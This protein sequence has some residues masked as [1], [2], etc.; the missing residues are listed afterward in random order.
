MSSLPPKGR[1][2][3]RKEKESTGGRG[4]IWRRGGEEV[5]PPLKLADTSL[6]PASAGSNSSNAL[7]HYLS[8]T[9]SRICLTSHPPGARGFRLHNDTRIKI[10]N[11]TTPLSPARPKTTSVCNGCR[12]GRPFVSHHFF[13]VIFWTPV[14]PHLLQIWDRFRV[15]I[16]TFF[17]LFFASIFQTCF[18]VLCFLEISWI[19]EPLILRML[20][21]PFVREKSFLKSPFRKQIEKSDNFPSLVGIVF[22]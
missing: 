15:P 19:L 17:C 13:H 10:L 11:Q 12:L 18:G 22:R 21:I 9:N 4:T 7:E 16:R 14:C 3:K 1:Q 5:Q 8:D 2:W 20:C 6:P